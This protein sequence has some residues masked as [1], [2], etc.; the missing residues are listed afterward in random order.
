VAVDVIGR[1]DQRRLLIE[2][3]QDGRTIALTRDWTAVDGASGILLG[4]LGSEPVRFTTVRSTTLDGFPTLTIPDGAAP[5][6]V[7]DLTSLP[8]PTEFPP[9]KP[10][11]QRLDGPTFGT[12]APPPRSA[13]AAAESTAPW[14][15][16]GPVASLVAGGLLLV[17]RR[18]RSRG[19]Q[20]GSTRA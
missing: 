17:A 13:I 18:R 1:F 20:P 4:R 12:E 8:A 19:S 10:I 6:V 3:S 16:L 15:L 2:L 11:E 7:Y 14:W 9:S 5:D